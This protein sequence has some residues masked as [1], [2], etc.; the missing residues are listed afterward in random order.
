MNKQRHSG[1]CLFYNELIM[2]I[3]E[4]IEELKKAQEDFID[5]LEKMKDIENEWNDPKKWWN[6]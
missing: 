3:L 1:E 4:N 6:R 5:L 2:T